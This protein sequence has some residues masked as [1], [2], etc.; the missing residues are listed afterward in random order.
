MM[1]N[2][3]TQV[4]DLRQANLFTG[5][6]EREL[7]K[8]SRLCRER[9]FEPGTTIFPAGIKADDV[10]ILLDGQI[11]IEIEINLGKR[12]IV[13]CVHTVKKGEVFAWSSLVEPHVLTASARCTER[14]RVCAIN[15][16]ALMDMFEEFPFM[17]LK[18]MKNL[19]SVISSRLRDTMMGLQREIRQLLCSEW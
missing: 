13:T 9:F 3:R 4:W 2:G 12:R 8:L 17:G 5:L 11:A 16:N 19:S 15:G 6:S 7:A 14:A 18:V 1:Q 10:Y